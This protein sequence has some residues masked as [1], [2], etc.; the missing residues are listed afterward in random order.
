MSIG[1]SLPRIDGPIK[2]T[3]AAHYTADLRAA[4]M[5]YGVLVTASIPAGRVTAFDKDD[6][7]AEPGVVR[8]LTHED[9]LRA[10]NTIAGP[11]FA[12]SYL[13]M[14]SDEVRH[15]GQPIALVL[16]ETLEAAEAGARKVHIRYAPAAAKIPVALAWPEIDRAA[17]APRNT[18]YFFLEPEFSKGNAGQNLA[19]AQK[20]VEAVYSQPSR[21]HNP[22]EP[23]A[24]LALWDGDTLTVHD[25]TQ[26]VFAVQQGLA[27]L[28]AIPAV[29]VRVISQHTGG[30]FGVKGLIWPHEALAALAAKIV[31]RPVRIAL[32]RANMYSFLG[33]QPRI[34]QK[35]GLGADRKG[36]LT[37][38]THDVVNL[39]T[40][41]DDFIE[42]AT[43]ASKSLYA[44]PSMWL[45]QRAERANVAMPTAMRAPGEGPGMWALESAMDELAVDLGMDPLDLRLANYAE[46]DPGTRAPWSSKKLR[47]AYEDGARLFGWRGRPRSPQ[48]DG[49]WI[50][51]QGMAG[52]FMGTFRFPSRAQVRLH[53]DGTA[54]IESGTQDIGTGALTI[55]PQIAAGV[56]GLPTSMIEFK[57]GDTTLPEAGPTYGSSST[58]GVGAAVFA[59]AQEVR[60]K[61]ARLANLLPGEVTMA[62]G[63]IS[64]MGAAESFSIADVMEQAGEF[65]I[66]GAGSFDPAR[67][68]AGYFMRTF[69]AV[70]VEVGVDPE[71]GL[72]RLRRVVGSYS[73]G[74]VVN[75]RTARAQLLGG[76]VW[77]WGMAAMEQSAFEPALGR[78]LS[79]N[80]AGVAIP[81]NADIP[82]D[83]TVHFV[84]EVDEKAS[85]IGGKGIGELGATGVAAAVANA[86]FHATGKRI[87]DL[88]ITPEKL[89]A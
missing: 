58:M 36:A 45:R 24:V 84:D 43:E 4:N 18:G 31:A 83:I 74:R 42:F 7:L 76:I 62:D 21:H 81:V 19:R 57:M 63:R 38:I 44:T 75:P 9:M 40:V 1:E 82:S 46:T 53:R 78:F 20:R 10:R 50:V 27:A 65:E 56:L 86:V 37:A 12:H 13:P 14:Q 29:S 39:T 66:L 55:F 59:A 25:S 17:L 6:A 2:V 71:L 60:D 51:G 73:V 61:L 16:G 48:R 3:G 49:D 52:C 67:Y 85:P 54:I 15:E 23:S 35:M 41:T 87:R 72:V 80:L 79:K 30:A 26:H 34:V 64:R 47:E 68:G 33:Y 70:F 11:P 77:G 32:S 28:F 69:G 22:M 8:V 5:L 88:P 89:I